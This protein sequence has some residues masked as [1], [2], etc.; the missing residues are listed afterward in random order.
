MIDPAPLR[1]CILISDGYK[2]AAVRYTR[3][4][5][6]TAAVKVELV[7]PAPVQLKFDKTTT[8]LTETAT[9]PPFQPSPK[10]SVLR[11]VCVHDCEYTLSINVRKRM[12]N[13]YFMA[14]NFI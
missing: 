10:V 6:P 3:I 9:V 11:I 14:Q 13:R 4:V 12:V 1:T 2:P 5:D 7:G 8:P